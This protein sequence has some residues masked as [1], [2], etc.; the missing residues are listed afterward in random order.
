M[1]RVGQPAHPCTY[2]ADAEESEH[3]LVAWKSSGSERG[4]ICTRLSLAA[5]AC[6]L[7]LS[8]ATPCADGHCVRHVPR[9][10]ILMGASVPAEFAPDADSSTERSAIHKGSSQS[11]GDQEHAQTSESGD[12]RL[13]F[14]Q[15]RS[16]LETWRM[17]TEKP[18]IMRARWMMRRGEGMTGDGATRWGCLRIKS[19]TA[20]VG[21]P[22]L[23]AVSLVAVQSSLLGPPL[24]FSFFIWQGQESRWPAGASR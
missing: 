9:T 11:H 19:S 4:R 3:R 18:T 2:V 6:A 14:R 13:E 22:R 17:E 23:H 7:P 16:D 24:L 1:Y 15:V 8:V 20:Q 12:W 10:K 21:G 5:T